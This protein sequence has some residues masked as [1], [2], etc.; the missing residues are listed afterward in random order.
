MTANAL[1]R[2]TRLLAAV[3]ALGATFALTACQDEEAGASAS[4][5]SGAHSPAEQ[6]GGDAAGGTEG[7]GDSE[8]A[9]DAQEAGEGEEGTQEDGQS[10]SG[11][12]GDGTSAG[13]A[14]E[15]A[16]DAAPCTDA[17]TELTVTAVERPINHLLLTVTNT[18]SGT[19][20]AWYAPFLR[21]GDAQ[22]SVP[23]I[24]ESAPQ[25]VVALAPGESAYAGIATSSATGEEEGY[26]ATSLGVQFA[27]A[28]G[29]G[30]GDM[31]EVALPGGEVYVDAAAQVTYWQTSLDEALTW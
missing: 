21:F 8:Q 29:H 3:A 31:T 2:R 20:Y 23:R 26:T 24:E 16:E 13:G 14:G 6:D 12:P 5:S 4:P 10:G 17:N 28:D 30:A 25:A 7:A 19:C 22:A 27:G 18:G 15:S 11:A 1:R 9:G